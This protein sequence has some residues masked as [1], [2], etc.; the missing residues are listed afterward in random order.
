MKAGIRL[1][2]IWADDDMLELEVEICDGRS[3]FANRIYVG[4]DQLAETVSGLHV[5]K[6]QIYDGLF[7]LRFG[8]FGPEY[9][10]GALDAR[11][12]F[13]KQGKILVRVSAQSDFSRFDGREVASEATLYL[14]TEPALLDNFIVAL[15]GLSKE[16]NHQSELEAIPWN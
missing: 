16:E 15:R 9:A 14:V 3:L 4:H 8:E 6:D 11:L 7:N 13:R 12:H 1:T 5:F 2:R 10:S